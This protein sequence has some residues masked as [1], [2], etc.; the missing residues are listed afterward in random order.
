MRGWEWRVADQLGVEF[1]EPWL[2]GVVEY[3]DGVDH[4]VL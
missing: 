3:Q 1:R 2:T 4:L